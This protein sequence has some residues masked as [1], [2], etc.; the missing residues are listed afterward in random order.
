MFSFIVSAYTLWGLYEDGNLSKIAILFLLLFLS[1]EFLKTE[2]LKSIYHTAAAVFVE[3]TIICLAIF[4]C[5]W[6]FS[7]LIPAAVC[8]FLHHRNKLSIY[9]IASILFIGL[10]LIPSNLAREYVLVCIFVFS[11]RLVTQMLKDSKHEYLEKIDN[12][13]LLNLQLSKLKTQLL[14]SQQTIERL[15]AQNQQMKIATSLHDTVGHNLAAL[16]I[17]LNAIKSLL[18]KKGVLE[19][20]QIR[21]II[22]SCLQQT[23]TSYESLKKFV[24]SMKNS[25]ETKEKYLS[26]L[27]ENFNFCNITLNRS[28][29]IENIPSHVFENLMAILKEALLNV[30][31]HSNATQVAVS[32]ESKPTYVRLAVHDNGNNKGEI[33]EGVGLMSIK[34]R[35]KSMGATVNIDNHAGFSIVVF[36]PMKSRREELQ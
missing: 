18:E 25:F 9:S 2:Y 4:L 7:F 5:G 34:L 30:A 8:T 15:S 13:G 36:V 22:S 1:L 17:Q 31:K 16:N 10:F 32:L 26:Q 19:D 35:A 29:D 24:Y 23:Q 28:G 6:K 3:L 11:L 20:T 21:Q 27:I 12:L 33:K 14:K